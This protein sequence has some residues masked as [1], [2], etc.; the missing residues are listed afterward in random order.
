VNTRP[1]SYPGTEPNPQDE[2]RK[3]RLAIDQLERAELYVVAAINLELEN[4]TLR[5]ALHLL[6]GELLAVQELL[7]KPHLAV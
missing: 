3:A 5:R 7:H 4:P 2:L 1:H 6:R